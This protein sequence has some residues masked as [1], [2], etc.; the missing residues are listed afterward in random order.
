MGESH[1]I[2]ELVGWISPPFLAGAS[3]TPCPHLPP[4][5]MS[6]PTPEQRWVCPALARGGSGAAGWLG[7]QVR[8]QGN[9]CLPLGP[10]IQRESIFIICQMEMRRGRGFLLRVLRWA[11]GGGRKCLG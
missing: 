10:R 11:W 2:L 9:H 7:V 5:T 4:S 6:S 8:K 1:L 3:P